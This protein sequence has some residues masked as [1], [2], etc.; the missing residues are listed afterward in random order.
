MKGEIQKEENRTFKI[1]FLG[2]AG[3]GKT[4]IINRLLN[5]SFNE[6]YEPTMHKT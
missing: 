2:M 5:S 4:S 6:V 1:C 3:C